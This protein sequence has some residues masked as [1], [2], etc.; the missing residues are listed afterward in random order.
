LGSPT[1]AEN[2]NCAV[3]AFC[4]SDEPSAGSRRINGNLRNRR[5]GSLNCLAGVD[6][7]NLNGQGNLTVTPTRAR[8]M[9]SIR[10]H[11]RVSWIA[12]AAI[13]G[14]L[15]VGGRV[16]ACST[17]PAAKPAGSCCVA[18]PVLPCC[19]EPETAPAREFGERP[20]VSPVRTPIATT[21]ARS[22]ECR[23]DRPAAPASKPESRPAQVRAE[24]GI[25]ESLPVIRVAV[26]PT[27]FIGYG[28]SP[29]ASRADLPLFLRHSRLLF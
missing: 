1:P 16:S 4:Q 20:T 29:N 6:R 19:C 17:E 8:S 5:P 26:R 25:D 27:V 9:T 13:A 12:L 15:S 10:R 28:G 18:Q 7:I 11:L 24:K 14:M 21:P 23:S 22:C 3:Y 2:P